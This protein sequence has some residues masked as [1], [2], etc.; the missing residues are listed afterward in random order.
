MIKF[1]PLLPIEIVKNSIIELW[2]H[3]YTFYSFHGT[4]TIL[5]SIGINLKTIMEMIGPNIS[6]QYTIDS[7]GLL[8]FWTK[9]LVSRIKVS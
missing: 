1:L 4:Q 7:S 2:Q 3:I 8:M 6:L 5:I 9:K